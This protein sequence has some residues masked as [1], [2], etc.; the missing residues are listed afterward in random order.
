[1]YRRAPIAFAI[2]ASLVLHVLMAVFWEPSGA[3]SEAAEPVLT[4]TLS[5]Q[6]QAPAPRPADQIRPAQAAAQAQPKPAK[7]ATLDAAPAARQQ[8]P[9]ESTP[10]T[11]VVLTAK[12]VA[13][14]FQPQIAPPM[15]CTPRESAN[16]VH[17][18]AH[19]PEFAP[20][21][22]LLENLFAGD[23]AAADFDDDMRRVQ[24]LLA[25]AEGLAALDPTDAAQAA[26]VAEQRAELRREVLRLDDAYRSANLLRLFPMGWKALKG[27]RQQQEEAE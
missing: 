15:Q 3:P 12:A 13:D 24:T 9:A 6:A 7:P 8:D 11:T 26:L 17:R 5:P 19:E 20:A 25:R 2:A 18:C 10:P 14:V 16:A 1:M 23:E 27:L 21:Q 22:D 4:I